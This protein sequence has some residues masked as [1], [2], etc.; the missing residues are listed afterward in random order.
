MLHHFLYRNISKYKSSIRNP[1][2]NNFTRLLSATGN[3]ARSNDDPIYLEEPEI[4]ELEAYT[5]GGFHPTD[6][7]DQFHDGRYEVVH[8]LGYGGYSLIWL[9]RDKHEQ[10]Y[11][12]L[13][14]L[15]ASETAVTNEGKILHCLQQAD[16]KH[17]GF[18]VV[19]RLLD[20]FQFD[21]PN[22]RHLCLVTDAAGNNIAVSKELSSNFM[23][24]VEAAR[25]LCAQLI[26][27]VAYL[28]DSGICHGGSR[29]LNQHL[30]SFY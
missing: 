2:A 26:S 11:V 1:T 16:N 8:K 14:M 27:G 6:I 9:A 21:G 18:P 20:E 23:F 12:A 24:P 5:P 4:E 30:V 22:G 15:A 13:K 3:M 19:Q 10:R 25:S 7:G 28:H 29:H 17:P